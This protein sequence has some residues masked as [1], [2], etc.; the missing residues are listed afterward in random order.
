MNIGAIVI[1]YDESLKLK[2]FNAFHFMFL[3]ASE[4]EK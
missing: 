1:I 4:A 3:S 2:L